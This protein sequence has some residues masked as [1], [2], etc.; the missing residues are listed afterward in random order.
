MNGKRGSSEIRIVMALHKPDL[1]LLRRQIDSIT[2][3]SLV[4]TN[5]WAVLDGEETCR[6]RQAVDLLLAGEFKLLPLA[7]PQGV[8]GAFMHGLKAAIS[9]PGAETSL[10]AFADQD[11][12]WHEA[13]LAKLAKFRSDCEAALVH[14][15]A[16]L[17]TETGEVVSPSLHRKEH[18][19]NSGGLLGN[20]LV[21]TV[22]GMTALFSFDVARLTL[23]LAGRTSSIV[24]H[25]H[26][27][28][29][30]AAATG[31]LA[32]LDE[33]LVD[34]VQHANNVVGSKEAQPKPFDM[35]R[36]NAHARNLF[37]DRRS[38]VEALEAAGSDTGDL[39]AMFKLGAPVARS[40]LIGHYLRHARAFAAAGDGRRARLCL[41]LLW[42]AV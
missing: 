5:R 17:V 30:A 24:L 38:I 16:R 15:D 29:I 8:R 35:A 19:H 10:F 2:R 42:Q 9:A 13:K 7:S 28:S 6:N 40:A 32:F 31:R 1:A 12:D 37:A 36:I 4:E 14:C 26:L 3:Q 18:R 23:E 39:R 34:Y 21:N 27:A 33:P 22:S 11:D 20:L 41:R 25:D